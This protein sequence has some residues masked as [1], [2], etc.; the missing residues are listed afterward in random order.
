MNGLPQKTAVVGCG[1]WG[2]NLARNI[3]ANTRMSLTAICDLDA[4]ILDEF[5]VRYPRVKAYES[6]EET[7]A[8]DDIDAVVLA[9]PSGLH[10]EQAR[11]VLKAGKH[12]LVEKPLAHTVAEGVELV[13]A[14]EERG[15]ILMV[16][17]TFL[18]NNIVHDIQNR[19]ETGELGDILYAYSQRLNLGRFRRDSDV[20]WT[21]A[22]HDVSILNYWFDAVPE[23]VSARGMVFIHKEIA[24]PEV[25]FCQLDY[26]GGRVAHLHLSWLD[27]QKRR[28]MV[29]VGSDKMLIYDDIN[30]DCHIQIFDKSVALDFHSELKDFAD[31]STRVRAGD[32]IVPN[33]RLQEP[34]RAEVEAFAEAIITSKPPLTDGRH[35]LEVVAVLEAISASMARDGAIVDVEYP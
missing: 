30:S 1:Y 19:I 9:T 10:Y 23:R 34:L 29:I 20:V 2:P 33:I 24:I 21:L 12:V 4:D 11:A 3:A 31:F 26:P 28:E 7:L 6:I 35:G 14:A 25:A 5:K 32:L 22:P 13:A 27:P 17:H 8:D 15:L 16:G 18:Y